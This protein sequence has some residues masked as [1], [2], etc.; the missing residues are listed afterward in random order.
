VLPLTG[1]ADRFSVAPGET[2]GFKVSSAARGPYQARLVRLISGDP[3]PAGPG[4]KEEPVAAPFAGSY[5]SR[6]QPVPLGSHV[7]VPDAPAF[8]RLASFTVVATLWPTTPDG[9]PGDPPDAGRQGIVARHDP[10]RGTGFA[11]F[12]DRRGAGVL[13]GDGRGGLE[14]VETGKPLRA[15]TWYRV[16]ASYDAATRTLAVGQ[17]PLVPGVLAD[18]AGRQTLT[19]AAA[20]ALD[21]EGP[22]LV[23][24]LG[25]SPA[26]GHYNGKIER[27]MLFGAALP[28]EAIAGAPDGRSRRDLVA[29]WDFGREIGGTRV[30]DVGPSGLHGETVN[31]PARAVTGSTWTGEETCWRHA[32]AQY[33]A[34]HFHD[35]D[36]YDCG[37]ETDFRFTVPDGL[38]SG[39]YGVRLEAEGVQDTIPFFVR[40]V[41][42]RPQADA[43]VLVPTFTYT[44][45]ANIARDVIDDAYRGR[46]AAWGARPWTPDEHPDYGLSTYNYHRDGSGI[47][48][49]SRLRPIITMRPGFLAYFD[50][51]GSGVRHLPA[52]LHLLDWLEAL[53]HA[54]DVVTDEDLHAEGL[55]LLAPYRVV[56]TPT[57]PEYQST[58]TWDALAAYLERGGRLMYLGGNGFYWRVAVHPDLPGAVEVR[59]AE[60][61]IRA[62][63]AEPGEAFMSLD[64][65]YG[66]LW[67]RNGRPPQKLVGVGFTS[68]GPF[69]GSYYR[70]LPASR[71]PRAAW[72]FD[73]VEDEVLGDFGLS[74]GGAAGF[75]LDRADAR[76][77][78]PPH[79]LVVAR[80]EGH[81]PSRF[82]LVWEDWLSHVLTW[83]GEP[84]SWLI[85]ADMVYFETPN[86]GAVFSTGSIT[87][88]GSLAHQGY[89]NNISRVVDNVLRRFRAP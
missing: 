29:A 39:V 27:P 17:A 36:L 40:P 16:W 76:L 28:D 12:V 85:R 19:L 55:E 33:A 41:R 71:D 43:C 83:P 84:P 14:V 9:V 45:Y 53:G 32:P 57:H 50:P 23:G 80:S 4:I 60:G 72:I 44:V 35:D 82:V 31:L 78:T 24:A 77:G 34:I 86:G 61:G 20:P 67:R 49:S 73:G 64:G 68:Q 3:N 15:R 69:E 75:E 2:I 21:A 7:R 74:G 38:R 37:W 22:L 89:R 87:F 18:D 59:R 63:A 11:L 62:W 56:L 6:V 5:P 46:V 25:G 58:R 81:D 79:A 8:R 51:R 54:Y 10:A 66:G 13:V 30:V 65:Q 88:C 1:Y 52:D 47:A 26:S 70:R 42:G 48:Y